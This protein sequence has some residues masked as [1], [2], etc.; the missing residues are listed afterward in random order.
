MNRDNQ[1]QKV[2]DIFNRMCALIVYENR[3]YLNNAIDELKEEVE[4]LKL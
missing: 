1:I 4:K 2:R 3:T